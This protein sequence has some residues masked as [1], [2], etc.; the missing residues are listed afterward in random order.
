MLGNYSCGAMLFKTPFT[1]CSRCNR[2]KLEC[3]IESNFKRVG[4]R[5]KH[6]EMEKQIDRL[7]RNLNR[8]QAQ[9][10]LVEDEEEIDSPITNGMYSRNNQSY[11]GSDEA[12]SSL[13]SS[14]AGWIIQHAKDC[15]G[16]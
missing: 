3:K 1:T 15:E 2:L 16:D 11:M 5:S 12:V 13:A 7:R 14:Q 4:K 8:A 6:A 9:G 10:F